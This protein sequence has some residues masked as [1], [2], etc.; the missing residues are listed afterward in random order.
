MEDILAHAQDINSCPA[1]NMAFA[2]TNTN[3]EDER[4]APEE[5]SAET[6]CLLAPS[7]TTA[8]MLEKAGKL[9]EGI[10]KEERRRRFLELKL[11]K[12][13]AQRHLESLVKKKKEKE[14]EV[15]LGLER[16]PF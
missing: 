14:D 9:A 2:A 1:P 16:L 12:E 13:K 8:E 7:T 11:A 15:I 3:S 5:R 4:G 6:A 10:D